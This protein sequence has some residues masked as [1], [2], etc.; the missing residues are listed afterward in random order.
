MEE[1]RFGRGEVV[2]GVVLAALGAYI[3]A[4]ARGWEYFGADGPGAGFFP[5]WYGIAMVVLALLLIG[6]SLL[7]HAAGKSGRPADWRGI[8]RALL[9][10]SA[11]AS[12][13]A[14]LKFLGFFLSF[15][16]LTLF[17]VAVMYRRPL[18][19]ALAVAIGGA[20]GFYLL[21]P[22][23]LNVRLPMGVFGI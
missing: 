9:V 15:A 20:I 2:S 4:E 18:L 5:L 17:I 8:G 14:L 19:Q 10:W 3:I 11:F 7:R 1:S 21:F 13:I 12:S 6:S 23:A 22:L 16:L